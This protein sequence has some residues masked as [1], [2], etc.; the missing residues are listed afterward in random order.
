ML[1]RSLPIIL[2]MLKAE[3]IIAFD[4]SST[5]KTKEILSQNGIRV[6]NI[7]E[8]EFGDGRTRNLSLRYS[9][10]DIFLF[11]NGDAI[12]IHGWF[13][14]LIRPLDRCDAAFSRQI[15]DDCCDPLRITD[16]IHHPYFRSSDE[17]IIPSKEG[18]RIMFDTV[19]CA[20]KRGLLSQYRFPDVPF[21]ED[22][23]W[24]KRIISVGKKIAYSPQSVVIHS[25]SLYRDITSLIRRHFEEGRLR[26][27]TQDGV[28]IDFIIK[29]LPS[30]FILDTLT[31]YFWR[32]MNSSE[33]LYWMMKEPILR[34]LQLL[35]FLVGL[36]HSKIPDI[37][38][39][40]LAWR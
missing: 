20:I 22:T 10:S 19:S 29:F 9:E 40:R 23:I 13:S 27:V 24:A 30:A 5:D 16:L 34:C 8:G 6:I 25:H 28:E 1:Q 7:P 17:V 2:S 37:L 14:N 12:P 36:N 3:D 18:D 15:P 11:L 39:D 21:G 26:S 31:L 33:K 32:N 38:K 35:F 4:S